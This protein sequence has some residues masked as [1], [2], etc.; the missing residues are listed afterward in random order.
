MTWTGRYV[1]VVTALDEGAQG[2][3]GDAED[4]QDLR[5]L[6]TRAPSHQSLEVLKSLAVSLGYPPVAS[7][8]MLLQPGSQKLVLLLAVG[9]LSCQ[10]LAQP[11]DLFLDGWLGALG[12]DF[13]AV[14]HS[15]QV[16]MV[17][18]YDDGLR[19]QVVDDCILGLP[20]IA[21]G[22][23]ETTAFEDGT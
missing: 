18:F 10:L 14:K 5:Q 8:D 21:P 4:K 15:S 9:A 22:Q 16:G 11:L 19:S 17:G 6:P 13:D 23:P 7:G 1:G 3:A 20:Q 2:A 12:F